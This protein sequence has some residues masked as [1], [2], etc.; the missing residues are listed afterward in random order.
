MVKRTKAKYKPPE[1][2]IQVNALIEL[3]VEISLLFNAILQDY[4]ERFNTKIADERKN[5][6]IML[7]LIQGGNDPADMDGL[8]AFEPVVRLNTIAIQVRCLLLEN[9]DPSDYAI[10]HWL[11]I[12][13]HEFVHVCQCLTQRTMKPIEQTLLS[14]PNEEYYFDPDE[15]EARILQAYYANKLVTNTVSTIV[16]KIRDCTGEDIDDFEIEL[17]SLVQQRVK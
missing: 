16:Q 12:L 1:F 4:C 10:Q 15:V 14:L 7:S 6:K 3:D 8:C 13:T 2:K 5:C 11:E 9:V 17:Q